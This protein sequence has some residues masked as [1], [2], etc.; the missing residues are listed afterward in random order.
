MLKK[1][2]CDCFAS[3]SATI[4]PILCL[5]LHPRQRPGERQP[6]KAAPQSG[7]FVEGG[8]ALPHGLD[9]ARARRAGVSWPPQTRR[10]AHRQPPARPG[11]GAQLALP[12]A[13]LA[14]GAAGTDVAGGAG[15]RWFQAM[16]RSNPA[17]KI[18][19]PLSRA[20]Q[21]GELNKLLVNNKTQ[22]P[23]SITLA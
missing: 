7:G 22:R 11:A 4:K 20:L 10:A 15:W 16:L 3:S 5:R 1:E 17:R 19:K 23:S 8:L 9:R 14:Q 6:A 18:K 13:E 21:R 12:V 2:E